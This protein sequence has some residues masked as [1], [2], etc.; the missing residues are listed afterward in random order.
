MDQNSIPPERT[1]VLGIIIKVVDLVAD[2][3]VIL[4]PR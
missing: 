4:G 1:K 3:M 2:L